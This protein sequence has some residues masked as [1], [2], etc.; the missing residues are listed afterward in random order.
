MTNVAPDLNVPSSHYFFQVRA[1]L[2]EGT[3]AAVRKFFADRRILAGTATSAHSSDIT[4][5]LI[6]DTDDQVQ[7]AEQNGELTAGKRLTMVVL[8]MAQ[9]LRCFV[10][11][12]ADFSN[13]ASPTHAQLPEKRHLARRVLAGWRADA[14]IGHSLQ[15]F[16][17]QNQCAVEFV[18]VDGWVLVATPPDALGALTLIAPQAPLFTVDRSP[19]GRFLTWQGTA[20]SPRF[21]I[22]HLPEFSC[23]LADHSLPEQSD[24]AQENSRIPQLR[25]G[26]GPGPHELFAPSLAT[27]LSDTA[28]VLES[29]FFTAVLTAFDGPLTAAQAIDADFTPDSTAPDSSLPQWIGLPGAIQLLPAVPTPWYQKLWRRWR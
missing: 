8:E 4:V 7:I 24:A 2:G 16:A 17:N 25:Y 29:E 20:E 22:R 27:Q 10:T 15:E 13:T 19:G 23:V 3:E 14:G 6:L 1:D 26:A 5:A 11:I 18:T 12:A 9:R 21:V 28:D